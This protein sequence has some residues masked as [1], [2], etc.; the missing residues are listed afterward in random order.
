MSVIQ[1]VRDDYFS[2]E[3]SIVSNTI[4]N[5][6]SSNSMGSSES[7]Q[8]SSTL[9]Q[10]YKEN[11]IPKPRFLCVHGWR[12]SG[13]VLQGQMKAFNDAVNIECQYINAPFVAVGP[14]DELISM[15]YPSASYSYYEWY[16]DE[17]NNDIQSSIDALLLEI[18]TNGPYDG[19]LGFSQGA[20]MCTR[21]CLEIQEKQIKSN[22]TQVILIGGVYPGHRVRSLLPS[23][24]I[25]ISFVD[26]VG[27][28]K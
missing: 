20:E 25:D 26:R 9:T 15:F 2:T 11:K 8:M 10:E 22:I 16:L 13:P 17:N 7:K 18:E 19:L 27:R 5:R 6:I 14:P 4:I 3:I 21:L 23:S 24:C 1:F 28:D 12:T